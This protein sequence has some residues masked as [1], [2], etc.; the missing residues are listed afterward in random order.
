MGRA[1]GNISWPW[2][3]HGKQGRLEIVCL[4][5]CGWNNNFP[6]PRYLTPGNRDFT[7]FFHLPPLWVVETLAPGMERLGQRKAYQTLNVT[8]ATGRE[9]RLPVPTAPG[10]S[11]KRKRLSGAGTR[12]ARACSVIRRGQQARGA[13]LPLPP[14]VGQQANQAR[15]QQD[16][17]RRLGNV[18]SNVQPGVRHVG[19]GANRGPETN[20][21]TGLRTP[22]FPVM[23]SLPSNVM[24]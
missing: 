24:L 17:R 14:G 5:G 19:A 10:K 23:M 15:G 3:D 2:C 11:K 13:L 21:V 8:G 7:K 12:Q 9:T 16:Q 22:F 6:W 18:G 20:R 1:G 4:S